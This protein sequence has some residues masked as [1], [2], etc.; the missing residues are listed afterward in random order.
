MNVNGVNR[1]HNGQADSSNDAGH[2]D[3]RTPDE[4]TRLLPNRLDSDAT[5]QYLSPDDPAVTPYNLWSVRLMRWVTVIFTMLSFMWWVLQLVS[6]FVTPPGLQTRGSV[7]F[8]FGYATMSLGLL[9]VTLLFFAVPSKSVRILSGVLA[10]LL[11]ADTII[12]LAV[13]QLRHE[14]AFVGSTSVIWAFLMATWT[15]AAD[16]TVQWGKR[17]EEERLT[18]RPETRRTLLE[19]TEVGIASIVIFILCI[20][21]GLMTCTLTIRAIDSSLEAPG[22]RYWVDGD[23]YQIHVYCSGNKTDDKTP[24]VLI[25]GGGKPVEDGLWQFFENAREN[26]T[27]KRYC[28]ADRPGFAWSDTAPSP[29]SAGMATEAL[30]EALARAGERGPWVLVGAGTGTLYSRI[31]SSRHGREVK[32]MMMIDPAHEDLLH[33]TADPGRGFALWAWGV[34]S[35]LGIDRI[36]GAILRGRGRSDRVWG[37]AVYQTEKYLF[38][39][40]QENLVANSLTKRDVVSSRAIQYKSTP[41][42]IVSS[43]V[44]IRKDSE[45]EGKQRD[46]CSLTRNLL[47]WDIAEKSPHEVWTTPEGRALIEKRL[48]LLVRV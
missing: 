42:V 29:L 46:L 38:A 15:L 30:S 31:F 5:P 35:P 48:R 19:W 14:E 20:T 47:S 27:I 24:T 33:R 8:A 22:V 6:M 1:G 28:F 23:K 21:A 13:R 36:P 43:G 2:R 25:E 12:I 41:L 16:H 4:Y 26:G 3:R 17:E 9:A 40:L 11:L 10:G 18:G 7:F 34:L 32:G 44:K 45:W 37:R 39:K